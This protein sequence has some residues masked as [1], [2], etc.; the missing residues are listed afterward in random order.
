MK[1]AAELAKLDEYHT[2]G[3]PE[4]TDWFTELLDMT[5]KG[6]YLDEGMRAALGEYYE[7]F[8]FL[9]TINSRSAIQARLP[10]YLDIK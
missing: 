7:P 5:S 2:E 1:K 4:P 8:R 3:Y 9:K 10:Y 6:S